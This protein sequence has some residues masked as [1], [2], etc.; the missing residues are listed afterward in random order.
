MA[1]RLCQLCHGQKLNVG[2]EYPRHHVE[3]TLGAGEGSG[4]AVSDAE[5]GLSLWCQYF[6]MDRT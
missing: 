3:P 2:M 5:V 6:K 1:G 4:E